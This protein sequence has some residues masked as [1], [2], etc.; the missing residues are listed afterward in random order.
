LSLETPFQ[1]VGLAL[2]TDLAKLE[3]SPQDV[4]RWQRARE[5]LRAGRPALALAAYQELV[6]R[7]PGVVN[8]WFEL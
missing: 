8:L 2:Q 3:R 6:R 7:F 1:H 4:A 5:Q